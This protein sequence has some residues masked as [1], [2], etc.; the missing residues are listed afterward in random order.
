VVDYRNFFSN[1]GLLTNWAV[2][3]QP[4]GANA[5]GV[6][7]QQV[8]L[9]PASG[10]SNVPASFNPAMQE[11]LK[12][13]NTAFPATDN[14]DRFYDLYIYDSTDDAATNY[15]HV[16]IVPSTAAKDGSA[17]VADLME[18]KWADVKVTLTAPAPVRPPASTSRP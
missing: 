2:P 8:V 9:D 7:Y 13:T 15:D 10:W 18:D 17:A 12:V 11:Q 3:G 14:V 5:F 6:S 1:R 16:L 4:A